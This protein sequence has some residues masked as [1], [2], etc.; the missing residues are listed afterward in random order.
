MK[1]SSIALLLD[2]RAAVEVLKRER[3]RERVNDAD[4]DADADRKTI[5]ECECE[6]FGKMQCDLNQNLNAE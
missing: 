2:T 5:I 4:A 1:I 3:E 6:R